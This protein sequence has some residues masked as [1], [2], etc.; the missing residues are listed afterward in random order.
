MRA[1]S[2]SDGRLTAT[3][4]GLPGL[5]ATAAYA[6]LQGWSILVPPL[7][8]WTALGATLFIGAA[9]GLYPALR[10]ARLSP[11]EALRSA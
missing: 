7:A 8:I 4:S 9:A 10:A 3:C 5:A 6:T 2:A 11:T 1:A